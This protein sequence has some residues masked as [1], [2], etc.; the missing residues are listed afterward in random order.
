MNTVKNYSIK[1]SQTK[2]MTN[3]IFKDSGINLAWYFA[4]RNKIPWFST[5]ATN[6]WA[7]IRLLLRMSFKQCFTVEL[8]L[9][10]SLSVVFGFKFRTTVLVLQRLLKIAHKIWLFYVSSTTELAGNLAGM[11]L[12]LATTGPRRLDAG[13]QQ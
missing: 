9:Y 12:L 11:L 13:L 3:V 4:A 5:D 7:Y 6:L 2:K 10:Y 8:L 1:Y